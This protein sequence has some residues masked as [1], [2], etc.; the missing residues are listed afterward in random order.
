MTS[1]QA[2]LRPATTQPGP[3]PLNLARIMGALRLH[4]KLFA[5]T[6]LLVTGLVVAATILLPAKWTATTSIKIEPDRRSQ[7]DVQAPIQGMPPDQGIIDTE[8]SLITSREVIGSVV[9]RLSLQEDPRFETAALAG[10]DRFSAA[11]DWLQNNVSAKRVGTTYLVELSVRSTSPVKSA[12]IANAIADAY[13]EFSLEGRAANATRQ[14][15][16]LSEQL[17]TLGA[18]VRDAEARVAAYRAQRGI[19]EGGVRGTI[20]DQRIE[21]LAAQL[22]N[23]EAEAANAQAKLQ[24]ARAQMARGNIDAVAGVLDSPVITDLRRQRAE[25][26][27]KKNENDAV[28][29]P[30]D[31]NSIGLN[32]QLA[33]LDLQIRQ[34]AER[35]MSGLDATARAASSGAAQQRGQL[36]SLRREQASNA[37]AAVTAESLER[38]AEAKRT[39]YNQLAQTAQEAAQRQQGAIAFGS[40]VDRAEPPARP[41]FPNKPLLASLGLMLGL[42]AGVGV[43]TGLEILNKGLRQPNELEALTGVPLI[44]SVPYL[45]RRKLGRRSG[46]IAPWDYLMVRP[47]STYGETLRSIRS[48]LKLSPEG[49]A[50]LVGVLSAMASEGKTS[51]AV[52]LART[53]ALSGDRVLLVAC[54]LRRNAVAGFVQARPAGGLL[55]V[56]NGRI[57]LDEALVID[58]PTGLTILPLSESSFSARDAFGGEAME[59]L[60]K[61][62]RQRF[63]HVIFDTPPLLA[64]A[65]ARRIAAMMDA[66]LLVVRWNATSRY[67]VQAAV[68]QLRKDGT[69]IWGTVFNLTDIDSGATAATDPA[70]YIREYYED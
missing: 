21:P 23:A 56:L 45:S 36:E 41:S 10:G 34:E 9:K 16:A 6:V 39:V 66:N 70:S 29:G 55:E 53:M 50:G 52:S 68:S 24:A 67:A 49:A 17:A 2:A 31:L 32:E 28:Y 1:T 59:A 25:V 44:A 15:R 38:D 20:T 33:S 35:V 3:P 5:A 14:S 69:G 40:V 19:V 30:R 4:W 57:P 58:E 65:D 60:L 13:L 64:V 62:V 54:D 47:V 7:T 11:V 26:M 27:R 37:G 8:V 43:V 12:E 63:E 46:R 51:L 18:E 48:A 22:G 61:T 42:L